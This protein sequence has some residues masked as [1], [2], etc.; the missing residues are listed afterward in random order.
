MSCPGELL[1]LQVRSRHVELSTP[2]SEEF[3]R[4]YQSTRSLSGFSWSTTR[5][6]E[7]LRSSGGMAN[8]CSA[9]LRPITSASGGK[10]SRQPARG[11][12]E[13]TICTVPRSVA[14]LDGVWSSNT[15]HRHS[16]APHT[17]TQ[18]EMSQA[19]SRGAQPCPCGSNI[20]ST[21]Q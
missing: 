16:N 6:S 18:P 1:L 14:Q 20:S 17:H 4:I 10:H 15:A 3:C 11:D 7:G 5:S 2:F 21:D 13:S 8:S 9:A 19:I 12:H